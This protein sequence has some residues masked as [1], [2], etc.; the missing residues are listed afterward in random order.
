MPTKLTGAFIIS[1]DKAYTHLVG[2]VEEEEVEEEEESEST[3]KPFSHMIAA[4]RRSL[5]GRARSGPIQLAR[6]C[7]RRKISR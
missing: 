6:R 2:E 7:S 1:V 3:R 5:T 4:L